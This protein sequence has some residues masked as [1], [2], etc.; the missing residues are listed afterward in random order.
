MAD[1]RTFG[2]MRV[3]LDT[4][5]FMHAAHRLYESAGF[6]DC[7]P[8]AESEVPAFLHAKWRFMEK[9][10]TTPERWDEAAS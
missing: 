5:P 1:A 6:R 10:L 9:V 7:A 4:A 8:Y 3:K 2:Y